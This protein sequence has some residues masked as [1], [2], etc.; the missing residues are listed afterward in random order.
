MKKKGWQLEY[1][2]ILP[3]M[4]LLE[5]HNALAIDIGQICIGRAAPK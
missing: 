5:V 3:F 2:A 1:I 4:K